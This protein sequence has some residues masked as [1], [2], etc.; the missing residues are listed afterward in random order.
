MLLYYRQHGDWHGGNGGKWEQ[1]LSPT[2]IYFTHA[3]GLEGARQEAVAVDSR[4]KEAQQAS[5]VARKI[6][7]CE[8]VSRVLQCFD[9][10]HYATCEAWGWSDLQWDR[11]WDRWEAHLSA[12]VL[13]CQR[14]CS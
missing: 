10:F 11:Q 7:P 4:R 12:H 2:P 9:Y 8:T 1:V 13:Q 3:S 6:Y 14:P 5:T